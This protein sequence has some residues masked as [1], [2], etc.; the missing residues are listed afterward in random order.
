MAA[1]TCYCWKFFLQIFIKKKIYTIPEFVEQRYSSELKTILAVFWIALY[2]FVNLASVLYLGGLA[3]QTILG[4][5][6]ISA[7][8]GLALFAVAYSLYGGLSAVAWTDIIQV[9]VLILG[10]LVTT[11]LALDTHQVGKVLLKV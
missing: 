4:V 10:G 7:I 6:M 9:V 8:I 1:L 11:Y 2:I 3:L 5:N